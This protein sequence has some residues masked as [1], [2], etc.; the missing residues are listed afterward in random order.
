VIRDR[1]LYAYYQ[2]SPGGAFAGPRKLTATRN[3]TGTPVAVQTA[4]GTIWVFTRTTAGGI[5]VVAQAA[6]GST[7]TRTV[8]LGGHL[9]G[10]PAAIAAQDGTAVVYAIGTD[11]N[12][13]SYYQTGP[14][15]AF[16][17]PE[18]LT[19]TGN[20]TGTPTA[21]QTAKG[22]ISVY[23]RTT[24]GA[25]KAVWQSVAGGPV[26]KS[27]DLGG[28]LA[29]SPAAVITSDGAI[30]V[31]AIGTNGHLYGYE[32]PEPGA[33]FAGP[34]KLTVTGGLGGTPVAV[35]GADGTAVV[36][37]LTV[38]GLVRAKWQ[39]AAYGPFVNSASLSGRVTGGLAGVVAGGGG[40]VSLYATAANG[41]QYRDQEGSSP[42]SFGGWAVI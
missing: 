30:A 39:S 7:V 42:R 29:G 6:P 1:N 31:Y 3:L 40:P 36:Y 14:G 37:F 27:A 25:V 5:K 35:P 11:R 16:K 22:V 12:L 8:N 21:V 38:R 4:N 23:A 19:T 33:R 24:G 20:L 2:A 34:S 17:G 10:S 15:G 9:A 32:Q 18:R 26:T 13:Y 41:R 28:H